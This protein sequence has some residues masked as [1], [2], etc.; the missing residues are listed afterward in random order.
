MQ[1]TL[2][3]VNCQ[4]A[5]RDASQLPILCTHFCVT[6]HFC[7]GSL[8]DVLEEFGPEGRRAG[9]VKGELVLLVEGCSVDHSTAVLALATAEQVGSSTQVKGEAIGQCWQHH[10]I[11]MAVPS[12]SVT[13]TC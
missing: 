12:R 1:C 9:A 3:P 4:E 8:T 13:S 2:Q 11:S 10:G 6:H 5:P 7:R